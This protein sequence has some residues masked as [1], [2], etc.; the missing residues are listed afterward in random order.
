[1]KTRRVKQSQTVHPQ[2][3]SFECNQCVICSAAVK[4]LLS[5]RPHIA[6][7]EEQ[8]NKLRAE[9]RTSGERY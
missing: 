3:A 9:T 8:W 1:M 5:F 2:T 6:V 7:I 4:R